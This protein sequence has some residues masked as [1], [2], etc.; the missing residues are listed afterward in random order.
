[1][2]GKLAGPG[3]VLGWARQGAAA[4]ELLSDLLVF[5][6]PGFSPL[7]SFLVLSIYNTCLLPLLWLASATAVARALPLTLPVLSV[8]FQRSWI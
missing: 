6:L 7:P 4:S 1:M 5:L 8:I 3:P 2:L